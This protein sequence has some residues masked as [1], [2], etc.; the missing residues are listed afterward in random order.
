MNDGAADTC[1]F[2]K[3]AKGQVRAEIVFQDDRVFR[4]EGP[5]NERLLIDASGNVSLHDEDMLFVS[6]DSTHAAYFLGK[7]VE[8]CYPDAIKAFE[9]NASFLETLRADRVPQRGQVASL[10]D[11]S[12]WIKGYA[13]S[14]MASLQIILHS[15]VSLLFRAQEECTGHE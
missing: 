12:G 1:I 2:C 3:L 4:V 6:F 10:V 14:V 13:Q 11:P 15:C 5:G 7:R 9:V 8:Q